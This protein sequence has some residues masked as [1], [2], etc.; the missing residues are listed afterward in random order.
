MEI[1]LLGQTPNIRFNHIDINNGLTSNSVY[2]ICRDN[3]GYI[4]IGGEGG[5]VRFDG[6]KAKLYKS[7]YKRNNSIKGSYVISIFQDSKQ[8]IW[9]CTSEAGVHLYNREKDSFKNYPTVYN[10]KDNNPKAKTIGLSIIEDV[11]GKIWCS[12]S[13]LS[14]FD[15]KT[16]RFIFFDNNQ[17]NNQIDPYVNCLYS[18]SEGNIWTGGLSSNISQINPYTLEVKNITVKSILPTNFPNIR[19]LKIIEDRKHRFWLCTEKHGLLLFDKKS[20]T[21]IKQFNESNSALS[22]NDLRDAIQNDDGKLWMTSTLSGIIIFDPEKETFISLKH[23]PLD[24]SS[25]STNAAVPIIKDK[26]GTIWVGTINGGVNYYTPKQKQIYLFTR[27]GA[28]DKSLSNSIVTSFTEDEKHRIYIGTDKGGLNRFTPETGKMEH[29]LPDDKNPYSISGLACLSLATDKKGNIWAGFWEKGLDIMDTK[30]DR[31]TNYSYK[32]DEPDGIGGGNVW[33]ICIDR[34]DSAWLGIYSSSNSSVDFFNLKSN[35]FKHF[36]NN[37]DLNSQFVIKV[38]KDSKENIWV[39]FA[40]SGVMILNPTTNTYKRFKPNPFNPKALKNGVSVDIFEDSKGRLWFATNE[41]LSKY[42]YQSETF[43]N[44]TIADGFPTDRITSILEDDHGNLWLGTANGICKFNPDTKLIKNYTPSDGLQSKEFLARSAFK[45]KNGWMYFGGVQGFNYFHPDSI[46][47][48]PYPPTVVITDFSI[49]NK[50]VDFSSD[51]AVLKQPIDLAKEITLHYDQSVISFEYAGMSFVS[52]EKNQYAYKLDG[53]D[54]NWNY[55][56]FERKATYTRLAPGEYN[57]KVKASNNDGVWSNETSVK[58]IVIPPYWMTWW[59]R[60]FVILLIIFSI[61][62]YINIRIYN[63]KKQKKLLENLVKERTEA[64]SQSNI[65][66]EEQQEEIL[67]QKEEI[68]QQNEVL[69]EQKE[70]IAIKNKEL[71]LHSMLL[72]Q[73][74]TER[75]L[76]LEKALI[77]A[78]ESD[79][80]KSAFLANM[81]H[82]IRTPMNSIIGFSNLLCDDNLKKEEKEIF[83]EVI[84]R[85]GESL[86]VLIDDIL[87]LSKIEARQ[88]KMHYESVMLVGLLIELYETFSIIAHKK[89]IELNLNKKAI[90]E[91]LLI[92]TEPIRLRQVFHNI[93]GNAIKFTETGSIDFGLLEIKGPNLVFFVKDTGMGI[94][95]DASNR[96]FNIFSKIEN[97]RTKLFRGAGL[98][99]AISKKLIQLIGGEIWYESKI[100]F[101]TTFFFTIPLILKDNN[102]KTKS[103][104]S[105]IAATIPDLSGK[106]IL[107]AEDEKDNFRVLETFINKTKAKIIWAKNGLEAVEICQQNSAVDLILMDI[108]M[109]KMSGIDAN[110]Q[111]K[112]FSPDLKVIAQTAFAYEEDIKEILESGF[113]GYLVK[114]IKLT[115]LMVILERFLC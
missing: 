114:P 12:G 48:N 33:S 22:S 8:Q 99:L 10:S 3:A 81:S 80:L 104:I 106:T 29:F 9:L 20:S 102:N 90:P 84:V 54:N 23:D 25:I 82:E 24:P 66:L 103:E 30:T 111:I 5:L 57:F 38:Y 85:S 35:K 69:F 75:T 96:I 72:E 58:L 53:F 44:Y 105:D 98:G 56:G 28:D 77:K 39:S 83:A 88:L 2:A 37:Q 113:N 49:F 95:P 91:G 87:D 27:V 107:I 26:F 93:I 40:G 52:N 76:D 67:L 46:K 19:I 115:E 108:K 68:L 109:P 71:E 110:K 89:G 45:A 4:W 73:K 47:D 112:F 64:L 62:A 63:I 86:L 92:E 50:P 42:D 79:K 100:N 41:G 34:H 18:D 60:S 51:N 14:C 31:F 43:F 59:F 70:Q 32:E 78:E 17:N 11:T 61:I 6:Y 74:V 7:D 1:S 15:P 55:V 101:G 13:N 21:V 36:R 16:D 97:D 94:P 65:L